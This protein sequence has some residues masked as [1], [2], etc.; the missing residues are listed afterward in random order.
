MPHR[1]DAIPIGSIPA[2][3]KV[4]FLPIFG[5]VVIKIEENPERTYGNLYLPQRDSGRQTVG[6]VVA[7]YEPAETPEGRVEPQVAV[8]DMVIFGQY[9]GT[10]LTVAR[11]QYIICREH[12]LLTVIKFSDSLPDIEEVLI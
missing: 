2:E 1:T 4:E 7:V 12:D 8:G 5:K 10:I 11:E 3:S 9:T 6:K